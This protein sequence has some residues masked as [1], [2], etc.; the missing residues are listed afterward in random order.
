MVDVQRRLPAVSSKNLIAR[1]AAQRKHHAE[2]QHLLPGSI[3]PA[4]IDDLDEILRLENAS[5][6]GDRLARRSLRHLLTRARAFTLVEEAGG[7]LLGY[8]T[9]L[10]RR[11]TSLA[12]LYSI[13]VD[14]ASRGHGV[15]TALVRA[16][17]AEALAR[18]CVV[19]RLEVHQDN[20]ASQRLFRNLG[21]KPFGI[22]VEYYDDAA[23]AV[24][25]DKHLAPRLDANMA[26]VPYYAQTLEFT[27]GPAALMMAMK[28]LDDSVEMDRRQELRLWREA[29]TIY[30][31]SGHGGCGP[32]GLALAAHA[33]GFDVS[34]YVNQ[35]G[36]LLL[37]SVRS[38]EKRAVVELV[39]EDFMREIRKARVPFRL[40]AISVD[41][42]ADAIAGGAI[43][44]VL[45]SLYR[46]H[47]KR[48]PH[49]VTVTGFD[50][51]FVYVNDPWV[52]KKT[53]RTAA[54]CINLPIP[55][56]EFDRMARYGHYGERAVLLLSR[57][58]G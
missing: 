51:R 30:M 50:E 6:K 45:I 15:A 38:P 46:F 31:T 25:F 40:E 32:E 24:R 2:Y 3:R 18:G 49:W 42:L 44:V 41:D 34:V 7:R 28:A 37:E 48:A 36:P 20:A 23:D 11:G 33:R 27:C 1:T 52:H 26:R 19:M 35:S 5:F 12:R 17:E 8:V 43:P 53:G 13:A 21:Y 29:T 56:D 9:V 55:R 54:D 58:S 16:A 22:Y 39:H 14:P 10:L 47:R 4:T 57:R